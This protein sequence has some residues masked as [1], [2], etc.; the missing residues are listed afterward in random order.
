MAVT[1]NQIIETY[2]RMNG[3]TEDLHTF[4]AWKQQGYTVKKGEH[5]QHKISIWKYTAKTK[6][7]R[8]TGEEK[9]ASAMFMKTAAFFTAGQVEPMNA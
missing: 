3:I 1:N 6:T 7:D 5:S 2:K 4:A 8:E 9:D